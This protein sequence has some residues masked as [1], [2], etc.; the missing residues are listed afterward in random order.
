MSTTPLTSPDFRASLS[1]GR[2]LNL[3]C[4]SCFVIVPSS[5]MGSLSL[6]LFLSS[7]YPEHRAQFILQGG[8]GSHESVC[9]SH[10]GSILIRVSARCCVG[11]T[12]CRG[13]LWSFTVRLQPTYL[14][15]ISSPSVSLCGNHAVF[16]SPGFSH[17]TLLNHG[18]FSLYFMQAVDI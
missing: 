16:F 15:G 17:R 2:S 13:Q 8:D 3:Y 14:L 9:E 4:L 12:S 5:A 7:Q 10:L 18:S 11:S 1:P 6:S